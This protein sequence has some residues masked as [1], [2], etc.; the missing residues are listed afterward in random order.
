[1]KKQDFGT[2]AVAIALAAAT[3]TAGATAAEA[4]SR[5]EITAAVI[6]ADGIAPGV[7]DSASIAAERQ[8]GVTRASFT[9][10]R[11]GGNLPRHEPGERFP[12]PGHW[13]TLLA[14]LLGAITIARRR[15][16]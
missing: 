1:M 4:E 9:V 3:G 11:A 2:L 8:D 15:M 14:G 10:P 12:E 7:K 13:A 6:S 5:S 16:S